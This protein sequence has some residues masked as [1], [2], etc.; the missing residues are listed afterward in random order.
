MTIH[1]LSRQP[2]R[3]TSLLRVTRG[4]TIVELMMALA[5]AAIG[6]TGIIAT[7]KLTVD[8][9]MHARE[10]AV[11]NRIAAAWLDQLRVDATTWNHPSEEQATSDILTDT[12]WLK[13]A[14]PAVGRPWILPAWNEVREWGPAF[15]VLGRPIPDGSSEVQRYCSHLELV[16]LSD[17]TDPSAYGRIRA[18]VRVF[19]WRAGAVQTG[20]LCS[21]PVLDVSAASGLANYHFVYHTTVIA[22]QTAQ[23]L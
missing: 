11:A 16:Y 18:T 1:L 2:R 6:I 21:A 12:V 5:L 13:E 17:P 23:R 22:Q 14:Q 3:I 10:V 4:Y 19:W 8:S 15:D 7:Q 9:N 20:Q